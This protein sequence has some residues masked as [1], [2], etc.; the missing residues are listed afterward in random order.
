MPR[1]SITL[2]PEEAGERST[3]PS[4]GQGGRHERPY[5]LVEGHPL[6]QGRSVAVCDGCQL[7]YCDPMPSGSDIQSYYER[8][9]YDAGARSEPAIEGAWAMATLRADAQV[10]FVRSI[11]L[12]N[13]DSWLDIGAGYGVLLNEARRQGVRRTAGVEPTPVRLERLVANGHAAWT[14]IESVTGTWDV[15][16]VSHVLEH[17]PNPIEFVAQAARLLTPN[18]VVFCEV[19]NVRPSKPDPDE[20]HLLF[21]TLQSLSQLLVGAGLKVVSIR[22]AGRRTGRG[23]NLGM[24]YFEHVKR[25]RQ[26]PDWLTRFDPMYQYGE[27][28]GR[29]YLRAI[30]RVRVPSHPPAGA[31]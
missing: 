18:G 2:E 23:W 8:G 22:E 21:F 19:P 6:F 31:A 25:S 9:D 14:D 1:R 5:V 29:I 30:A 12:G 20:P 15:A 24:R 13:P 26:L 4:C 17:V 3:C 11:G 7:R 28:Q 10:N 16:S 27:A